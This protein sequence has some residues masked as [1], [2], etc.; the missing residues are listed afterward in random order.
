VIRHIPF[1]S[2]PDSGNSTIPAFDA[3]YTYVIPLAVAA[4]E[5][6]SAYEAV[7]NEP[8][9]NGYTLNIFN[10]PEKIR[11]MMQSHFQKNLLTQ[12]SL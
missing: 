11:E 12:D 4:Y 6:E 2:E 8:E 1:P 5:D 7:Y 9:P 3:V 10:F